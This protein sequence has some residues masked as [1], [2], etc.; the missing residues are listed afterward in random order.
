MPDI[1]LLYPENFSDDKIA[2]DVK[3]LF[4]NGLT[5]EVKKPE[6]TVYAALEWAIPTAIVAYILKP[7]F[8]GFLREAGK[9]H[10]L[11]LKESL[12]KFIVR[13]K[14][15]NVKLV[16]ATDSTDKLSDSY[17]QS[18]AISIIIQTKNDK[19]VKLLFDNN[20]EK[21]DWDNA[22][23]QLL[24]YVIENYEKQ[25]DDIMSKK[26]KEINA[27]NRYYIYGKINPLTKQVEFF[28]DNALFKEF[29][30]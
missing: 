2:E 17:T 8:D 11:S 26:L 14:Q 15:L 16:T 7:Y 22:I 25:P 10:Y 4:T 9:D 3:S 27:E 13:G 24:D 12:K 6:P 28:D 5:I 23:D 30:S 21:E 18:V 1:L 20:L 19:Q 29:K